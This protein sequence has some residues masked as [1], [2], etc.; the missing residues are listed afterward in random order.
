MDFSRFRYSF[1]LLFFVFNII[2]AHTVYASITNTTVLLGNN[3]ANAGTKYTVEFT[4]GAQIP[5]NGYIHITFPSGT[6]IPGSWNSE[7]VHVNSIDANSVETSGNTIE[8]KTD[9]LNPAG[10][11]E[12]I[13]GVE[14]DSLSN[15]STPYSGYTVDVETFDTDNSTTIEGPATSSSYT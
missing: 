5:K 12:V 14:K 1:P 2:P 13:I 9:E 6:T 11:T 8:I 7:A 4:T 10:T 3:T 15:P